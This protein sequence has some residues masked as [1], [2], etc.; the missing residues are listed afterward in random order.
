MIKV[1][2]RKV[3][4]KPFSELVVYS[5]LNPIPFTLKLSNIAILP[6]TIYARNLNGENFIEFRFDVSTKLLYEIT[7]VAITNETVKLIEED[8]PTSNDFFNCYIDENSELDINEPV[9][10]LRSNKSLRLLWNDK[11]L[12]YYPVAENCIA[13]VDGNNNLNSLS[14]INLNERVIFDILGF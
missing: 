6:E 4:V 9:Q 8:I 13:G 12:S 10:I 3:N 7:L 2:F 14:L 11:N 1:N 5:T